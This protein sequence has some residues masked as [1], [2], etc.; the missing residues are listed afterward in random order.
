MQCP[1]S[2]S[3]IRAQIQRLLRYLIQSA[4][5]GLIGW[6]TAAVPHDEGW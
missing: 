6:S 2:G 4:V 1:G 3:G 5:H